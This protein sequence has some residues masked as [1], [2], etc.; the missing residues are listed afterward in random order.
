[1][2][3]IASLLKTEISRLARKEVRAATETLRKAVADYR[4]EIAALKRRIHAAE[5]T[6]RRLQRSGG[7]ASAPSPSKE[8]ADKSFRFS[9]KGLASQRRRL[10]LSAHD[11]GLLLGT[12]GQSVY[13]WEAGKARPRARQMP[14]IAALRKL[15]KKE[16]S[17]MLASRR[18]T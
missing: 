13:N 9:A 5:Q 7:A 10:A 2:P 11:C 1:M 4:S 16:A 18:G 12:S 17:A 15:G 14:A 8:A 3:N 6:L